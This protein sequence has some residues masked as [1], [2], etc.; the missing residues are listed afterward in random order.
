MRAFI[1]AE[2]EEW[3][4]EKLWQVLQ[5]YSG[6]GIKPVRKENFHITIAF[7]GDITQGDAEDIRKK[8]SFLKTFEAP[9]AKIVGMSSFGS[10][11]AYFNVVSKKLVEIGETIRSALGMEPEF[12]PHVTLFRTRGTM[13]DITKHK[14]TYIGEVTIEKIKLK[15]SVLFPT[16]P[17]YSDVVEWTLKE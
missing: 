14:D 9:R 17:V 15:K 11:V 5:E 10:R 13:P 1:S 3:A 12:V 8:L 7:L 16:G 2:I 6:S 4:K